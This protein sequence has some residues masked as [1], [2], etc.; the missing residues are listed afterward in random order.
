MDI[1]QF[2]HAKTKSTKSI[3]YTLFAVIKHEGSL[4]SGHYVSF[5]KHSGNV[6]KLILILSG[7]N[8][9]IKW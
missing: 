8:L 5:T 3:I 1:S 7:F 4:E 6:K 9:M 2:T